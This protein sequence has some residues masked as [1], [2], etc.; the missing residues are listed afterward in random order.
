MRKF[1]TVAAI[2]YGRAQIANSLDGFGLM[3]P[4]KEGFATIATFWN[5]SL[6]PGR[7]PEGK[8]LITSFARGS[9]NDLSAIAAENARLLGISG[10]PVEF[11]SWGEDRAVPQYNV[12][13]AARVTRIRAAASATPGLHL[14]GN[15]LNGRSIGECVDVSFRVAGKIATQPDAG[16]RAERERAH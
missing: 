12:G 15:Y 6:F 1:M 13:H 10:G 14:V 9:A 3:M 2:A 11:E 16:D 8:V 4:K 7:A 5:S